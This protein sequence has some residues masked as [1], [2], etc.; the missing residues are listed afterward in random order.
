MTVP[1][2]V[3]IKEASE[4]TGISY[5]PAA[6]LVLRKENRVYHGGMPVSD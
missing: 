6:V 4:K 3:T 1:T 5:K 2:M